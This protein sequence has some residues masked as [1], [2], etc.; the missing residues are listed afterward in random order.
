MYPTGFSI[1]LSASHRFLPALLLVA[2]GCGFQLQSTNVSNLTAIS[3]SSARVAPDTTSAIRKTLESS[4]VEILSDS[5]NTMTLHLL[6]ER[7]L[8][9]SV[10]TTDII[11]AAAYEIRLE[12]DVSITRNSKLLA[13]ATL[14]A[15]RTYAVDSFN[16]SGSHE[17]QALLLDEMRMELAQQLVRRMELLAQAEVE[18]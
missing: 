12:L 7:S 13:N 5:P 16:L 9:H 10:A 14:I 17:E 15:E 3:L 1:L 8:R 6:D 18:P 2:S 4:N 11:D